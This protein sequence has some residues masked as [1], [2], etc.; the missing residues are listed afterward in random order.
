VSSF[1]GGVLN[2]VSRQLILVD[3]SKKEREMMV[4][5]KKRM[6]AGK[7]WS[8]T[9]IASFALKRIT[10]TICESSSYSSP[11]SLLHI[12]TTSVALAAFV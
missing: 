3:R 10:S 8:E 1:L 2:R 11:S 7:N 4:T 12:S 9:K 6:L 5:R